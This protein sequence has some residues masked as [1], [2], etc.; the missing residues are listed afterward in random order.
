MGL[1]AF[2]LAVVGVDIIFCNGAGRGD[3]SMKML[4]A[5]VVPGVGDYSMEWRVL[6]RYGK[7]SRT[8]QKWPYF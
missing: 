3:Y 5:M 4:F 2:F 1:V 7:Y 6:V 8:A